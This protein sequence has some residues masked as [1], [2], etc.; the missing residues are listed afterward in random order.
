[1]SAPRPPAS[2][3]IGGLLHRLGA[4]AT[5]QGWTVHSD[6]RLPFAAPLALETP[7][8]TLPGT[9]PALHQATP[10]T[11]DTPHTP[12]PRRTSP[13]QRATAQPAVP[14]PW[15]TDPDA[16][17]HPAHPADAV[18]GHPRATATPD[19][20]LPPASPAS[21]PPLVAIDPQARYTQAHPAQPRQPMAHAAQAEALAATPTRPGTADRRAEPP[22]PTEPPALMP[23]AP[24]AH[25][26]PGQH[27]AAQ[28]A[29]GQR[30][31]A[32]T[33]APTTEVHV[34]IGRIE[35]TALQPPA[36]R[37]RPAPER[38]QPV[39]LDEYLARKKAP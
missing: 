20:M 9:Q 29:P 1:M 30:A 25:A 26:L 38:A 14:A 31:S 15:P 12:S 18:H 11:A 8:E 7:T 5:G 4:R 36:P 34:H 13:A 35:V 10:P 24:R 27:P 37:T 19:P 2:S 28:H 23:A 32:T 17:A 3:P 21:P 6:A 16:A 22:P 33:P 39:S